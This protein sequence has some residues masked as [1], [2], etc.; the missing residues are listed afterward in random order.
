[1]G[2]WSTLGGLAR[3]ALQPLIAVAV[4]SAQTQLGT[5]AP[6]TRPPARAGAPQATRPNGPRVCSTPCRWRLASAAHRHRQWLAETL[7]VVAAAAAY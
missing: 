6:P 1:M 3:R 7:T 2:K 5:P 4:P